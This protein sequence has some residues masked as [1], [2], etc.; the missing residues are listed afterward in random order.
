MCLNSQICVHWIFVLMGWKTQIIL[1][2]S[3]LCTSLCYQ[4]AYNETFLQCLIS[5]ICYLFY[6]NVNIL[7]KNAVFVSDH[8][9]FILNSSVTGGAAIA[10]SWCDSWH[11]SMVTFQVSR[12]LVPYTEKTGNSKIFFIGLLLTFEEFGRT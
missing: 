9:F 12:I 6:C 1:Q 8:R 3:Q 4:N 7:F 5:I 10:Y 2:V 11:I